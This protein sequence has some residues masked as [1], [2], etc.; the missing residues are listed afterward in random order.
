MD[1][2][3]QHS[4]RLV[5]LMTTPT[6]SGKLLE[7]AILKHLTLQGISPEYSTCLFPD[8]EWTTTILEAKNAVK[9]G[10]PDKLMSAVWQ[11][12][13]K[14]RETGKECILVYNGDAYVK[15]VKTNNDMLGIMS[16]FPKVKVTSFADYINENH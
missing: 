7:H 1:V 16:E 4:T 10:T 9:N 11:L 5:N 15:Y 13:R 14:R 6:Q 3:P 12:E 2:F 8:F